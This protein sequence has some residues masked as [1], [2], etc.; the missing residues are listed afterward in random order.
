MKSLPI[1]VAMC[2]VVFCSC[3]TLPQRDRGR[4]LGHGVGG[5]LYEKMLHEE[6]VSLAEIVDLSRRRL[7]AP[8]IID[9]LASTYYVYDLKSDDV[10]ELKRAGVSRDVIDYMLS[11][12]SRFSPQAAPLW[13]PYRP[14]DYSFYGPPIYYSPRGHFHRW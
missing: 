13:Y 11:T 7:P 3:A 9:Y 6:P 2:A 5:A 4:L 12:P 14:F 10:L 1:L 8:F